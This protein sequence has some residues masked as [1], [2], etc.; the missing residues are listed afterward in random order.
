[1]P[2]LTDIPFDLDAN[3]L[4][5]QMRL[6]PNSPDADEF[7]EL[8]AAAREE[9]QPKAAYR[10]C[11]IEDRTEDAVTIDGSVFRSRLLSK[12][13]ADVQRVFPFVVT[14]GRELDRISFKD[15]IV[16]SYWWDGIKAAVLTS[17]RTFLKNEIEKG[18]RLRKT[19]SMSPG[20]GDKT[21]WPIEQ[22]RPLFALLGDVG[23]AIGV[24]L[25]PSLLMLPIKTLSGIR[26]PTEIDFRSCQVC[27]RKDC[28]LRRAPFEK[29]LWDD[30]QP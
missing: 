11:Y 14:C 18:F 1:M 17:A 3:A 6:D 13:L 22:Q 19:A 7:R 23:P 4:L 16:K 21:I 12:N 30:C 29:A 27:R 25:T 5:S 10:A 26:F 20:S 15:D 8:I 9:A 28:P 24:E 2:L